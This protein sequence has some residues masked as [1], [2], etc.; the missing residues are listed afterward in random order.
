MFIRKNWEFIWGTRSGKTSLFGSLWMCLGG[1]G[2]A[3]H[4]GNGG[5]RDL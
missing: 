2:Q 1:L 3:A 4:Q 5:D